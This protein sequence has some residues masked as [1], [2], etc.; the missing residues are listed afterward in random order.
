MSAR[1]PLLVV[2]AF[3]SSFLSAQQHMQVGSSV[4]LPEIWNRMDYARSS[5]GVDGDF[6]ALLPGGVAELPHQLV[7]IAAN[8]AM[9]G[10]FD[11]HRTPGFE[12]GAINGLALDAAGKSVLL[13]RN[14]ASTK[15]TKTDDEGRPRGAV[16]RFDHNSWVVTVDD[17][18]QVL[19]KFSFDERVVVPLGFALFRSGNVLVLRQIHQGQHGELIAPGA[20]IFSPA[21]VMLVNLNLPISPRKWPAA[22]DAVAQL[23]LLPGAADEVFVAHFGTEPYLL[24]VSADG[25][26]G[27]KV[28]LAVPEDERAFV[29][30]IA[31]HRAMAFIGQ[32]KLPA[33]GTISKAPEWKPEAVFDT[34]SGALLDTLLVPQHELGP[35]CY[36]ESGMTFI[37]TPEGTLDSL[38]PKPVAQ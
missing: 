38:V 25:T 1:W 11:L 5:C 16:F 19:N 15:I 36:S 18:G 17:K 8:G 22:R 29:Q 35:V 13:V 20:V 14:V 34:E 24:K 32:A 10:H 3:A 26:V 2:L 28:M 21:G 37:R 6:I 9:L 23:H 4:P 31:G 30:K 12:N 33:P 27:P 7:H